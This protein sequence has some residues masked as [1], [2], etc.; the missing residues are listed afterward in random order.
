M[1]KYFDLIVVGGG[2]AGATL[3][4]R[5]AQQ[6]H[7]VLLLER[8]RFPRYQVGESLLPATINSICALLGV[9]EEIKRA[10]FVKKA[11]GTFRWGQEDK[12]W[13]LNFGM[14]AQVGD[15]DA[16]NQV[17]AYQVRRNEFD[18]ILL[19]N[20]RKNGVDVR[21]EHTV[22]DVVTED[23]RVVG[24]QFLD[25][26]GKEQVA[27][28]RFVADASGHTS[29]V[30]QRVGQRTYSQFY[31]HVA[32]YCYYD[33]GKRLPGIESG[34]V[35]FETF[36]KG[37][38]WYIPLSDTLTSVGAVLHQD[39]AKVLKNDH[40]AAMRQ[41]IDA[42]PIIKD[43]LS[44]AHRT[45]QAPYDEVRIRKEFS[46][47][48]NRFWQPGALLIGDAACFVDVLLSSGVHLATYGA[49]LAARSINTILKGDIDEAVC[50]NE[51]ELRYRMEFSKFYQLLI[52]LYDLNRD[53][54]TYHTWLR[55]WIRTTH[56]FVLEPPELEQA[57]KN[58]LPPDPLL[59]E[60]Q[61]AY[62]RQLNTTALSST[63]GPLTMEQVTPLPL[64]TGQLQRSK[65]LT[66]WCV[67]SDTNESDVCQH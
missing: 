42:C 43:Y 52:G 16:G 20:A 57:G 29:R 60:R 64:L 44:N 39:N 24:V 50:L 54:Q 35:L 13:T 5:V 66:T 67:Q 32:A 45:T 65:D 9:T 62:L 46:Y 3:A 31:R 22:Q 55:T 33:N 7:R 34:N 2:P 18:H 58:G 8:A 30:S 59:L 56:A 37:W 27:N 15:P 38:L 53:A 25:D 40:E 12:Q 47:S 6:G 49:L 4:T 11:G 19:Q 14:S 10:G 23:G 48:N 17:F 63:N 21:E 61:V 1:S 36:D 28:A 51:F 26:M 41:F